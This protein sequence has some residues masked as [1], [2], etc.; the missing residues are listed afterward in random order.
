MAR[1]GSWYVEPLQW[2]ERLHC[3]YLDTAWYMRCWYL[4][5]RWENRKRKRR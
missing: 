1:I 4:T 2:W 5:K 3:V